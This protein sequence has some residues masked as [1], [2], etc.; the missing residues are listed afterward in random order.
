MTRSIQT[1][2]LILAGSAPLLGANVRLLEPT[3]GDLAP[4]RLAAALDTT[5]LDS[6]ERAPVAVSWPLDP[7]ASLALRPEPETHKSREYWVQASGEELAAG[8]SI[9]TTAPGALVRINPVDAL[10]KALGLADLTLR[11]ANGAEASAA[12]MG[13]AVD[14]EALDK[15]GAPFAAGTVA[16]R[17]DE[18]LG[19]GEFQVRAGLDKA[20]ARGGYVVHVLDQG[21]DLELGLATGALDLVAGDELLVRGG[22]D[23]AGAAIPARLAGFVTSPAGQVHEL[24]FADGRLGSL[25]RL[26][27]ESCASTAPGLWEVHAFARAEVDGKLALRT[28]RTAFSCSAATARFAG[29]VE[30]VDAASGALTATFAVD[31][32]SAGRYELRG[33]LFG[34]DAAGALVPAAMAHSAAWLEAGRGELRLTIDAETLAQTAVSGPYELRDLML[35]D[36]ARM[37]ILHRQARGLVIEP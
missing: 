9:F 30:L 17:L 6:V 32:A 5:A 33:T 29:G 31:A 34:T 18:Q 36:Q 14:P 4:T 12:S 1:L 35:I 27:L 23:K 26:T 8:F 11:G 13:L 25:A 19:A 10:D 24:H 21:S 37:G 22:I 16:F 20:T 28:V 2:T 7:A 3:A 15:A